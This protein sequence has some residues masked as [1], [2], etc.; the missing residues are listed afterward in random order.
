ML[1]RTASLTSFRPTRYQALLTGGQHA[2]KQWI[3]WTAFALDALL[4]T[5][6]GECAAF[7]VEA[8]KADS[9]KELAEAGAATEEQ[10]ARLVRATLA[11]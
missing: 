9:G 8:F 1:R 10:V 4:T 5:N 3:A 11:N 2:N 6:G 7:V